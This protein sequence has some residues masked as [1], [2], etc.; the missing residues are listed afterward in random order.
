MGNVLHNS[1][2]IS[3]AILLRSWAGAAAAVAASAAAFGEVMAEWKWPSDDV[4]VTHDDPN[5]FMKQPWTQVG[6]WDEEEQEES[7][8]GMVQF[9]QD[10]N[11]GIG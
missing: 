11:Q 5:Y 7:I 1:Q 2:I 8:V 4:A 3:I 9:S 6:F 10:C